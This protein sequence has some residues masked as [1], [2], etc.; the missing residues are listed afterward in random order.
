MASNIDKSLILWI[1]RIYERK[2]HEDILP[3]MSI[4]S[5][6]A[7]FDVYNITLKE[8]IQTCVKS[9]SMVNNYVQNDECLN[10]N[11]CYFQQIE[12]MIVLGTL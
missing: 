2:D 9:F 1:D 3:W 4:I 11:I 5:W 12:A 8:K 7:L 10:R 6:K